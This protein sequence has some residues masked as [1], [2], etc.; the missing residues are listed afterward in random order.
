[1]SSFQIV[2][3]QEFTISSRASSHL[4]MGT[5]GLSPP[6]PFSPGLVQWEIHD[7]MRTSALA[8]MPAKAWEHT[9]EQEVSS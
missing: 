9:S 6:R 4:G 2:A 3:V 1:M 8:T 7:S 5:V